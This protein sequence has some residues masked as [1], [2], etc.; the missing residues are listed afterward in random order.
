MTKLYILTPSGLIHFTLIQFPT[1]TDMPWSYRGSPPEPTIGAEIPMDF[2]AKD[3]RVRE[4]FKNHADT[5]DQISLVDR[6]SM[7]LT[8]EA[9][10]HCMSMSSDIGNMHPQGED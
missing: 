1:M 5:Y 4:L 6:L 3:I 7:H 8:G 10:P 9:K 2:Y